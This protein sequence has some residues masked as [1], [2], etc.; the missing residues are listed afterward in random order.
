[1]TLEQLTYLQGLQEEVTRQKAKLED[2]KDLPMYKTE[3]YWCFQ[4]LAK[5]WRADM[6]HAGPIDDFTEEDFL[7]S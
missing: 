2:L 5:D 3:M 6:P 4:T 1:M 7:T